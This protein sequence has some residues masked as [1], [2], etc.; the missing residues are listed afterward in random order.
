MTAQAIHQIHNLL[1]QMSSIDME[2]ATNSAG[3]LITFLSPLLLATNNKVVLNNVQLIADILDRSENKKSLVNSLLTVMDN[4]VILIQDQSKVFA[5]SLLSK[6]VAVLASQLG[7]AKL[8]PILSNALKYKNEKA[9][10]YIVQLI[11]A[12]LLMLRKRHRNVNIH[13]TVEALL[14]SYN[15]ALIHSKLTYFITEAL[16]VGHELMGIKIFP[17]IKCAPILAGSPLKPSQVEALRIRFKEN[18]LPL[19]GKDYKV[20]YRHKRTDGNDQIFE[21]SIGSS[22]HVGFRANDKQPPLNDQRSW[23]R[24]KKRRN[25]IR[26]KRAS[27]ELVPDLSSVLQHTSYSST[28]NSPRLD[29]VNN[30]DWGSSIELGV[31]PDDLCGL[32]IRKQ[33]ENYNNQKESVR[34]RD[35]ESSGITFVKHPINRQ[36]C[37]P[38]AVSLQSIRRK[39]DGPVTATDATGQYSAASTPG[40]RYSAYRERNITNERGFPRPGTDKG[41]YSVSH[42]D[43]RSKLKLVKSKRASRRAASASCTHSRGTDSPIPQPPVCLT[44]QPSL[45]DEGFDE[46]EDEQTPVRRS[47][48]RSPYNKVPSR[49][50]TKSAP[51]PFRSAVKRMSPMRNFGCGALYIP[52]GDLSPSRNPD[53]DIKTAMSKLKSKQWN[54]NLTAM[55]LIRKLCVHNREVVTLNTLE[56]CRDI[57]K[58]VNSLRS[59][60]SKLAIMT[61]SLMFSTL[62]RDMEQALNTVMPGLM[63]KAGEISNEFLCSEAEKALCE[64]VTHT[65]SQKC[66]TALL[67]QAT[68]KSPPVRGKVAYFITKLIDETGPKI[69]QFREF[70]RLMEVVGNYLNEGSQ[71]IRDSAKNILINLNRHSHNK[72]EFAQKMKSMLT[73]QQYFK[74]IKVLERSV[75]SENGSPKI[76]HRWSPSSGRK[77]GTKTWEEYRRRTNT[78]SREYPQK[79]IYDELGGTKN[80]EEM[81]GIYKDMESTEWTRRVKGIKDLM[82]LMQ[83]DTNVHP[84]EVVDKLCERINDSNSK[85]SIFALQSVESLLHREEVISHAPVWAGLAVPPLIQNLAANNTSV[86]RAANSAMDSLLQSTHPSIL[87]PHVSNIVSYSNSRVKI[88]ALSQLNALVRKMADKKSQQSNTLLT[89]H[90]VPVTIKLLDESKNE[91]RRENVTLFR[92]LHRALGDSLLNQTWK[93]NSRQRKTIAE[94]VGTA[95][96]KYAPNVHY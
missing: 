33:Y 32:Q 38:K 4:L 56:L 31:K 3:E 1:K 63:K 76:K 51:I 7:Y 64:M 57:V 50:G 53:R 82:S 43:I 25:S 23:Q 71:S 90:A 20:T 62:E 70:R 80:A 58:Q 60:N 41:H 8:S 28:N 6:T 69:F 68:N 79:S 16:A 55:N 77:S 39:Y 42:S 5:F 44:P 10:E 65:N 13:K 52:P 67:T 34:D 91:L 21:D 78:Q 19:L 54:E 66:L 88:S 94:I 86:R 37:R 87:L 18:Q 95:S 47:V 85:V 27:E 9:K 74:M 11:T 72:E 12:C 30:N 48:F 17:I 81:M 59:Q 24:H 49:S 15:P 61:L 40:K 35:I 93:L 45:A 29:A 92:T 36:N 14:A 73:E 26:I 84:T 46:S 75:E 2:K 22:G 83:D 89:K 96:K